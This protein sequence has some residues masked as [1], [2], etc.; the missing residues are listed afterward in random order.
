MTLQYVY[1]EGPYTE[2]RGYAF[3]NGKPTTVTDNATLEAIAKRADF[4]LHE[5][6]KPV[7][8]PAQ[9]PILTLR[10]KAQI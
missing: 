4:K 1:T 5:A 6:P 3:V 2:F 9:R 8:A 7:P 10:R